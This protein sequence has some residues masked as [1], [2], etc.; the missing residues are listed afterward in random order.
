M[1]KG[2]GQFNKKIIAST[3]KANHT[4]QIFK[5]S[6]NVALTRDFCK[7]LIHDNYTI[8]YLNWLDDVLLPEEHYYSTLI[9]V[10][11]EGSGINRTVL[12]RR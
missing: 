1:F 4:L 10:K 8:D 7:F 9:R 12:Y 6:K 3:D 5:G 11:I 2:P